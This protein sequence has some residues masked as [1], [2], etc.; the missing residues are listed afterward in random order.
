MPIDRGIIDQQLRALGEGSRWWNHLE[1]RDLPAVLEADECIAA[2]SRGK[3]ARL[4]WMRRS[5]LVVVTDRRLLCLRSGGRTSWRQLEVGAGQIVRVALRVGPRKGRVLVVAGG[6][7]YRLLVPRP[8]S[9]KLLAA[10]SRLAR[11]GEETL[12]GFGPA[13]MVR[14]VFDH[15][16]ALPAAALGPEPPMGAPP[17]RPDT[18]ASDKRLDLLEEQV[19]E[20]QQQVRFLEQLLRQRQGGRIAAEE[21]ASGRPHHAAL[22]EAP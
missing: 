1:L 8:D 16:L 6:H 5:W 9:Y 17:A 15:V 10:L 13:R 18:A 19:Q 20:L 22:P 7:T 14:R 12:S 11:S 4:R 2:I 21:L 3:V